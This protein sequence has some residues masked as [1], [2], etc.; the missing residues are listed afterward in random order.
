MI[1]IPPA[2]E[3]LEPSPNP[4]KMTIKLVHPYING[5]GLNFTINHVPSP[6]NSL[7]VYRNGQRLKITEDYTFSGQT[8]TLLI[9]LTVGEILTVDYRI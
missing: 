8:I 2:T 4:G 5:D 7:K 6:T 3:P 1:I 9:A